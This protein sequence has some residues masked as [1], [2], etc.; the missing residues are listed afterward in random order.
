MIFAYS[1]EDFEYV[2]MHSFAYYYCLI[3][4][5]LMKRLYII[6]CDVDKFTSAILR[7]GQ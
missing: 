4:K 1:D 7:S 3:V 5:N 6:K 2:D